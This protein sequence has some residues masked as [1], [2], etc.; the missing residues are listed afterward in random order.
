MLSCSPG[1]PIWE[2]QP[3][4]RVTPAPGTSKNQ[5][6]KHLRKTNKQK[7]FQVAKVPRFPVFL[8]G[9]GRFLRDMWS[10]TPSCLPLRPNA[11]ST[12]KRDHFHTGG[13]LLLLDLLDSVSVHPAA[14]FQRHFGISKI[15][16]KAIPVRDLHKLSISFPA[17]PNTDL[18]GF[19]SSSWF[20]S[21]SEKKNKSLSRGIICALSQFQS[22]SKRLGLISSF[23]R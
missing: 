23:L 17:V 18:F 21:N 10:R 12:P 3:A 9:R 19:L 1:C 5:P 13:L 7:T 16:A 20:W 22:K 15:R 6:R 11:K 2:P 8:W 4:P 14:F